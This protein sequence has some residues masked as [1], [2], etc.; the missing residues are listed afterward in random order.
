MY[1]Y[2][3]GRQGAMTRTSF[4]RQE[5]RG[6]KRKKNTF[7]CGKFLKEDNPQIGIFAGDYGEYFSIYSWE[8]TRVTSFF[9]SPPS[10][11]ILSFP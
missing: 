4:P 6:K 7:L 11:G 1:L 5:I 3:D 9:F 2:P 10:K 8:F